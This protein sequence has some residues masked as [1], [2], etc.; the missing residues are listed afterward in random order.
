MKEHLVWAVGMPFWLVVF[1]SIACGYLLV[2]LSRGAL[3]DG[4]WAV[5]DTMGDVLTPPFLNGR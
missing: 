4:F 1:G 3:D 5:C 2:S